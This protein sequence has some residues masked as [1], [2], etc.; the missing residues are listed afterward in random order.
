MATKASESSL[1]LLHPL[2]T[3]AALSLPTDAAVS[4]VI[5]IHYRR[6]KAMYTYVMICEHVLP[7]SEQALMMKYKRDFDLVWYIILHVTKA[8]K[9]RL[10]IV[11][12]RT[13]P[14]SAL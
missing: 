3:A 5:Y 8:R 7:I 6:G 2:A 9:K 1:A 10:K 13:H 12:K 4:S 14:V 11:H